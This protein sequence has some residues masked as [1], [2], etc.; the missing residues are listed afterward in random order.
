MKILF[1]SIIYINFI[2]IYNLDGIV[3]GNGYNSSDP[4][5]YPYDFAPCNHH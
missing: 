2:I 1:N 4:S 5:C 3:T